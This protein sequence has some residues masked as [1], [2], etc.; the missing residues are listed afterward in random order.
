MND[1][2]LL[3]SPLTANVSNNL[4]FK[5][6]VFHDLYISALKNSKLP[7]FNRVKS[8]LKTAFIFFLLLTRNW[9]ASCYMCHIRATCKRYMK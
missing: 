3:I 5:K 7:I 6:C 9:K 4:S 8:N 2:L 1:K